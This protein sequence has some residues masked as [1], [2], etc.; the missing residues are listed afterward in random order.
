M[1]I[2]EAKKS[3]NEAF[4][5]ATVKAEHLDG[6]FRP[7][8]DGSGKLIRRVPT[9]VQYSP[10][11]CT[12]V[13]ADKVAAKFQEMIDFL[14]DKGGRV[15]TYTSVHAIVE[16][17]DAKGKGFTVHFF[18]EKHRATYVYDSGY[19]NVFFDVMFEKI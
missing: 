5:K 11:D 19:K 16:F 10:M 4:P 18:Q 1:K 2:T 6:K 15:K 12:N 17:I 13:K 7:I 9:Y 8:R 14:T 3:F